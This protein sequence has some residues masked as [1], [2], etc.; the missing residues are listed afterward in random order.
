MATF[1]D[2]RHNNT[3]EACA[4]TKEAQKRAQRPGFK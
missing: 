3:L 1:H 4:K 2:H